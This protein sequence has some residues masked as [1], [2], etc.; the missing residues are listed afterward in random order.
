M[1]QEARWSQEAA[2]KILD[3]FSD[4]AAI[5]TADYQ[6]CSFFLAS[7]KVAIESSEFA[8]RVGALM[9]TKRDGLDQYK[10]SIEQ[11]AEFMFATIQEAV[12][13]VSTGDVKPGERVFVC[14]PQLKQ[15]HEIPSPRVSE[16]GD[17]MDMRSR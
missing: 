9:E 7:A 13:A 17:K 15:S 11:H 10:E 12:D 8:A 2:K 6:L 5:D 1:S 3:K 16:F 4:A 14:F